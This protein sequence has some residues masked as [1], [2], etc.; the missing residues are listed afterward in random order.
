MNVLTKVGIEIDCDYYKFIK[1]DS[2]YIFNH[3]YCAQSLLD[4]YKS[5]KIKSLAEGLEGAPLN[6]VLFAERRMEEKWDAQKGVGLETSVTS[7]VMR[8][9]ILDFRMWILS[10]HCA[11]RN[12]CNAGRRA[13]ANIVHSRHNK[14]LFCTFRCIVLNFNIAGMW[15]AFRSISCESLKRKAPNCVLHSAFR[16]RC[17]EQWCEYSRNVKLSMKL[18]RSAGVIARHEI[19]DCGLSC[20]LRKPYFREEG[21]RLC[22]GHTEH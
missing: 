8:E 9:R 22:Y 14:I 2:I 11:W 1:C 16:L 5:Q 10:L 18:W 21:I 15:P 17:A 19:W 7:K 13:R 4:K 20:T 12:A 6:F 3:R